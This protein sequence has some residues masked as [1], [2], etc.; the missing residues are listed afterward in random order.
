M[1]AP[2]KKIDWQF[3]LALLIVVGPILYVIYASLNR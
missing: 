2:D 3:F 1:H